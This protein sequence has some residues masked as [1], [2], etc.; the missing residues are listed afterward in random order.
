MRGFRAFPRRGLIDPIQD[1][2]AEIRLRRAFL[3]LALLQLGL[4]AA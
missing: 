2:A 3:V 4:A 1:S